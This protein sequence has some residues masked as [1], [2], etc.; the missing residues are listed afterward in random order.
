MLGHMNV[1]K[2]YIYTENTIVKVPSTKS[3]LKACISVHIRDKLANTDTRTVLLAD[4][5]P[6]SPSCCQSEI[7]WMDHFD[8]RFRKLEINE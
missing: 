5:T 1:K 6:A 4:E 8:K 3:V 2:I 7:E